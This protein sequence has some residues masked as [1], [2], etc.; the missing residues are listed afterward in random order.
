MYYDNCSDIIMIIII[1]I[2]KCNGCE[3]K[4]KEQKKGE[5]L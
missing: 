3:C 5:Q 2:K 1:N 4:R